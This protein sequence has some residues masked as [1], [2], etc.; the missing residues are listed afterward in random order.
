LIE[1]CLRN[2]ASGDAESKEEAWSFYQEVASLIESDKEV[3][4][5]S[6]VPES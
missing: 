1:I 6:M 3:T 4:I 2:G 5:T